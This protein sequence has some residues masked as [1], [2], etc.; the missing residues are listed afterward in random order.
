VFFRIGNFKTLVKVENKELKAMISLLDDP[1][2][3]IIDVVSSNL[4]KQGSSVIPELERAWESTLNEMVQERLENVIQHIQFNSSKEN[5]KRW[6]SQGADY[7]LDGAVYLAQFQFPDLQVKTVEKEIDKIKKDIWLEINNN[8]TALEKVKIL[9]YIIFE[10]YKFKRNTA[11]FYSP[12]NSY[13][14]LVLETRR[15]NPI[16]LAIVYLA[17]AQKLNLPIYGVNLPKNFIL[18]Y[19]DEYRQSDSPDETEDIL[20]YIN[21]YNK[22]SVLGKREIDYFIHQQQLEP[23][24]EYYVPCTNSDIIV[25]LINNMVLSYEKL[26]FKD[27]IER[28]KELLNLVEKFPST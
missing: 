14:N 13:I 7:I 8:L 9:N 24:K 27:K 12:Q 2:T 18:A 22:G 23:R 20:F 16:S 25:R 11:N 6:L 21:P 3:E 17:V 15:G 19:K 28:L 1:D 5:L 4:M 10:I 26:D